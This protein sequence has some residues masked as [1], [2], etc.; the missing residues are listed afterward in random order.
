MEWSKAKSLLILLML[1][2]NIYLG[3][4][5]YTQIRAEA[6]QEAQMVRDACALLVQQGIEFD[7]SLLSD[8]PRGLQ[9]WTWVRDIEAEHQAALRL[10][11]EC[12]EERSGG[13]IYTYTGVDSAVTFRSG[14]YIELVPAEGDMPDLAALLTPQGEDSRLS[15]HSVE[16]GFEQRFD[17]YPIWSARVGT[18]EGESPSGTWIFGNTPQPG[19]ESLSRAR[20][21]LA[22]GRLLER[23]GCRR[24]DSAA[25]VY[26]LSSLQNGDIRLVP[27][28]VLKSGDTE[29]CMNALTGEDAALLQK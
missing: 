23:S 5:I 2:V 24:L 29:I 6:V 15:L 14:G 7:E 3:V 20:L 13:G 27:A 9:S 25:C 16:G 19:E 4:S 11:G 18:A 26:I 12:R 22:A 28:L 10:L 1:A 8:L 17:G 21:I